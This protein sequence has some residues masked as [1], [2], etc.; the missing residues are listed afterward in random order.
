MISSCLCNWVIFLTQLLSKKGGFDA[1]ENH[2]WL[3][4][5]KR[6]TANTF[7]CKWLPQLHNAFSCDVLSNMEKVDYRNITCFHLHKGHRAANGIIIG[8]LKMYENYFLSNQWGNAEPKDL[9]RFKRKTNT[10]KS[11][12]L[13]DNILLQEI[14]SC[15]FLEAERFYRG[16]IVTF[17]PWSLALSFCYWHLSDA[18]YM[19]QYIAD[20]TQSNNYIMITAKW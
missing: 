9:Y 20:V 5:Q 2:Q 8:C 14:S 11:M 4:K 13:S 18:K 12:K 19:A 3:H 6:N 17:L 1:A 10:S 16:S 15:M 7:P